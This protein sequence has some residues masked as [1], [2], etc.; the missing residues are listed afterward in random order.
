MTPDELRAYIE[1]HA[2]SEICCG[3]RYRYATDAAYGLPMCEACAPDA[4]RTIGE[5]LDGEAS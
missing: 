1:A 2:D 4:E 5:L 3:C